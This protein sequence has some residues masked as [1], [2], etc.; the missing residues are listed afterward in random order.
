MVAGVNERFKAGLDK[1]S[2]A[3][4]EDA[5]FAEKV[6][7]GFLFEGGLD[8]AGASTADAACVGKSN[9]KAVARKILVNGEDVGDAITLC[10]SSANQMTR[11]FRSD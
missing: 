9:V 4:A 1:V 8:N 2:D 11:T 10:E 5:L 7:L 6:G 3:A